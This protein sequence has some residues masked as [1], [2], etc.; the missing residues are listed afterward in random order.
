MICGKIIN[1][2]KKQLN[3]IFSILKKIFIQSGPWVLFKPVR[4]SNQY[5]CILSLLMMGG[6]KPSKT[7]IYWGNLLAARGHKPRA[8]HAGACRPSIYLLKRSV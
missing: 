4:R 1:N 5:A 6:M 2:T 7:R 8:T 3:F